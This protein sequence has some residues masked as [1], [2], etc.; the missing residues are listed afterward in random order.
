MC[1][2]SLRA[3]G[4]RVGLYT[5]PHLR[6][7]RERIRVLSPD[8]PDG[9]IPEA[10]FVQQMDR[11]RQTIDQ[12]PGITWFEIVTAIAFLHFAESN[13]D[14]AVVEVGLGGRLDATNV[15]TPEV[16]VI[17]SLSLDHTQLLGDTLAQIAYEKG[18]IPQL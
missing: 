9:R 6:E 4:L 14:I 1:A 10:S 16:S 5:S 12:A 2:A 17:T 7:F 8:E 15:L 3:A 18:G 13:I 11:V